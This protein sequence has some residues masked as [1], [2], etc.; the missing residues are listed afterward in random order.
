[1]KILDD[2]AEDSHPTH[3][4]Y[5]RLS[6]IEWVAVERLSS[7]IGQEAV[8]TMLSALGPDGQHATISE[9]IQDELDAER[10]RQP[11][12]TNKGLNRQSC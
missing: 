5:S 2:E 7:T 11:C 3:E 4:S 8:G 6:Q 9:F 1:M 10:E 12:F